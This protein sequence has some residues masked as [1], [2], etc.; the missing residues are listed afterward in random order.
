MTILA[1]GQSNPLEGREVRAKGG[2]MIGRKLV[3]E[4]CW[5]GFCRDVTCFVPA[6]HREVHVFE[7]F[8]RAILLTTHQHGWELKLSR[9]GSRPR[10][11]VQTRALN[12]ELPSAQRPVGR[13]SPARQLVSTS[14]PKVTTKICSRRPRGVVTLVGGPN[15]LVGVDWRGCQQ[16]TH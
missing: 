12:L 6:S 15:L 4:L 2:V 11:C 1:G 10:G 16:S 7:L 14:A 5:L 13:L 3:R 8:R 9:S